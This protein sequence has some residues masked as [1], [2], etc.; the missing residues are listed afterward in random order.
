MTHFV[1]TMILAAWVIYLHHRYNN[2]ATFAIEET[3]K[4]WL[5]TEALERKLNTIKSIDRKTEMHE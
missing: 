2:L 5:Q 4:L 3:N 1:I